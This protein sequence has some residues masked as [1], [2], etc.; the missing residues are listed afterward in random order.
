MLSVPG[1]SAQSG[2]QSLP[3]TK[4]PEVTESKGITGIV[5]QGA[6]AFPW[7]CRACL[8]LGRG[9]TALFAPRGDGGAV[10]GEGTAGRAGN[11]DSSWS[12]WGGW[13]GRGTPEGAKGQDTQ[14]WKGKGHPRLQREGTHEGAKGQGHL[15]VEREGTPKGAKG[16]WTPKGAKGQGHLRVQRDRET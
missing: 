6:S 16:E 12:C 8:C 14:R 1:S 7:S 3:C 5:P 4:A 15:R 11:S 13:P 2:F 9:G 10:Q